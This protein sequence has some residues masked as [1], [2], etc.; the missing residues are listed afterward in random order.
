MPAAHPRFQNPA[1]EAPP[2]LCGA[3]DDPTARRG[4]GDALIGP[5]ALR[6]HAEDQARQAFIRAVSHELRTPLNAIIGFSDIIV[7]ELHGPIE[8]PR[9][10]AHAQVVRDSGLKLL[11]LVN[12]TLEIARLESGVADMDLRP[13]CLA[14]AFAEAVGATQSAFAERGLTLETE[15]APAAQHVLADNRGLNTVLVNLLQ[16][17]A[18]FSPEGGAVRMCAARSAGRIWIEVRDH[19]PGVSPRD[20]NRLLRPFQHGE[21][22]PRRGGEGHGLGLA[23]VNLTCKAMGGKLHLQSA[24]GQGLVAS[25][26]LPA[27]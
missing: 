13:E 9:Y 21:G 7:H 27:A 26:R 5:A 11:A 16:N 19:G 8:E 22:A 6:R 10:K 25:V 2:A 4:R 14:L 1:V 15:I 12:Q 23:V 24:P 17:A 3:T 18:Q 20:L